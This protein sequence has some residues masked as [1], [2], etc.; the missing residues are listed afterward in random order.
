MTRRTH[1]V[2]RPLRFLLAALAVPALVVGTGTAALAGGGPVTFKSH[3]LTLVLDSDLPVTI[4]DLGDPGPSAGDIRAFT[5][6]LHEKGDDAEVARLRG[7]VTVTEIGELDGEQVE[8]RS[9]VVTISFDG[10]G[11]IVATGV[12]TAPGREVRTSE[13]P[14]ERPIVGGTGKYK[15]ASGQLTQRLDDDGNVENILDFVTP[16]YRK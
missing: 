4:I 16:R 15:G 1:A 9:G 8:F 10:G 13:R 5:F 14:V 7:S 12:Y 3:K 2:R 6:P 11:S